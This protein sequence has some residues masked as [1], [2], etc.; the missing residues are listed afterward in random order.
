MRFSTMKPVLACMAAIGA[1][2]IGAG[3]AS[4]EGVPAKFSSATGDVEMKGNL[5]LKRNGVTVQCSNVTLKGYV[6]QSYIDVK[7]VEEKCA[8]G[9]LRIL[10]AAGSAVLDAGSYFLEMGLADVVTPWG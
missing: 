8:K 5:T 3:P 10:W 7:G 9:S 4:A 2:A 6:N 1:M